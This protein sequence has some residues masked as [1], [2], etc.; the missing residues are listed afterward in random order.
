MLAIA[1]RRLGDDVALHV[2]D[3]KDP[4]PFADGAF[5]IVTASL[6]L[7]DLQD[8]PRDLLPVERT[9]QPT[10]PARLTERPRALAGS[11]IAAKSAGAQA[12]SHAAQT[13]HHGSGLTA[14]STGT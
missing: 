10:H 5:D 4:L 1:K 3:L 14:P 9:G 12:R 7:H 11:S 13:T 2:A 6:V 8:C